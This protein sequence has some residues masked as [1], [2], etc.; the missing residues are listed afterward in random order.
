MDDC[1]KADGGG[2]LQLSAKRSLLFNE[3]WRRS[4]EIE[5]DFT[6]GNRSREPRSLASVLESTR[7]LV[8]V[9]QL[10]VQTECEIDVWMAFPQRA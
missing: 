1:R 10:R 7:T 8:S 4:R 3:T 9:G 2:N 6:D 5:P